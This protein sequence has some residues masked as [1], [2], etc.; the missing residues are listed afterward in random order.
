MIK[1][2]LC[3]V[4]LVISVL[5]DAHT[6]IAGAMGAKKLEWQQSPQISALYSF[7]AGLDFGFGLYSDHSIAGVVKIDDRV[8]LA[9]PQLA[10]DIDDQFAFDID[11]TVTLRLSID[12][13]T[14]R[15]L[16][17]GYDR[18]GQVATSTHIALDY[19][20][21]ARWRTIDIELKR[22]R[23]ANRGYKGTDLVLASNVRGW[24]SA[25]LVIDNISIL[26][27][28]TTRQP[29][30][31]GRLELRIVDVSSNEPV[32]VRAGLYDATGRQPLA[33]T[34]DLPLDWEDTTL[35]HVG[36][37]DLGH[38]HWPH[39]NRYA[40]YLD[41]DSTFTLPTGRYRLVLK[42][43][44]EYQLVEREVVIDAKTPNRIVINLQRWRDMAKDSWRSGD[45]HNHHTRM[46]REDDVRLMAVARAEDI[47]VYN[48]LS[49]GNAAN[50]A[51]PQQQMGQPGQ[52]AERGRFLIS[53]QEDPRTQYLGHTISLNPQSPVRFTDEYLDYQR[54]A[55]GIRAQ[56]GLFGYA[57]LGDSLF[58]V[59]S[60][61]ALDVADGVV[62]FVEVLQA[63]LLRT[64][65]WYNYLNLGFKI[66][67]A[68]GSD[69]PYIA[70]PGDVRSYVFHQGPFT[71]QDWFDG[72]REGNTFVTNGPMLTLSVN[73]QPMG[74]TLQVD[75][76]SD[77]HIRASANLNPTLDLLS[78]LELV[79]G[80]EVVK[81]VSSAKGSDALSLELV[82]EA[83]AGT[84]LAVRAYGFKR[85][86]PFSAALEAR[87]ANMLASGHFSFGSAAHSGPVYVHVDEYG[88]LVR[89]KARDALV[90]VEKVLKA[91]PA[92]KM[93]AVGDLESWATKYEIANLIVR[94]DR[95]LGERALRAAKQY[96]DRLPD[97]LATQPPPR[98]NRPMHKQ[99]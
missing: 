87:F 41:G 6:P 51:F 34:T 99:H 21:T 55:R 33:F 7:G 24:S 94:W 2:A 61:L 75:K 64:E 23:F 26:R 86:P 20:P 88:S 36:M 57:H 39:P 35:D 65:T 93:Q 91:F 84:W 96:A 78:A 68:A 60:G 15:D 95:T 46:T 27:R 82:L 77:L 17:Y 74:S 50:L 11:E 48:V 80:G 40:V 71:S 31:T 97:S 92:K 37:R 12:T 53:G 5:A 89:A 90:A 10:F 14:T 3:V 73:D 4:G 9:A 18:N 28:P 45:I 19:D 54:T 76:G 52:L 42:K 1:S 30:A 47:S 58:D 83:E 22:A 81:R 85:P 43:G 25:R 69:W 70:L 38:I 72:L 44:L 8:A 13:Y 16:W 67:P 98:R 63:S 59:K 56:G 32:F 79:V 49:M 29:E 66:P 62:D